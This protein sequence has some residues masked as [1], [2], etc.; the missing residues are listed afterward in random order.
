MSRGWLSRYNVPVEITVEA[1][2]SQ[3]AWAQVYMALDELQ[4]KIYETDLPASLKAVHVDSYVVMQGEVELVEEEV[5][6][7]EV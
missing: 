4:Y 2:N 1:H 6:D 5:N 7:A 3:H